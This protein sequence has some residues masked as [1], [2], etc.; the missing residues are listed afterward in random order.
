MPMFILTAPFLGLCCEH[1]PPVERACCY[2][3]KCSEFLGFVLFIP[4]TSRQSL[5]LLQG[6]FGGVL[7]ECPF[8]FVR[9]GGN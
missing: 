2:G 7:R 5:F 9:E 8:S 1:A 3:M 4:S 6:H